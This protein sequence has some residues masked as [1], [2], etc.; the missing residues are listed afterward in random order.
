MLVWVLRHSIDNR[1]ITSGKAATELT[2]IFF[3]GDP[4]LPG[5]RGPPGVCDRAEVST[6]NR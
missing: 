1:F 3:Q 4:G 6:A 2:I 5:D